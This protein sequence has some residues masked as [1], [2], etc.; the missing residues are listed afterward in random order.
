MSILEVSKHDITFLLL[1]LHSRDN[2]LHD[3]LFFKYYSLKND[4]NLYLQQVN[5]ICHAPNTGVTNE[6]KVW[7]NFEEITRRPGCINTE[8]KTLS[9][10]LQ[11]T[12]D[13]RY[14]VHTET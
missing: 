10:R 1:N 2:S 6:P 9:Q 8:Y 12:G 3:T 5:I 7:I 13:W 11:E 14:H 4:T